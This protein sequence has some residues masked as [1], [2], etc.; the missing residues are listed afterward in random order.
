MMDRD[1]ESKGSCWDCAECSTSAQSWIAPLRLEIEHYFSLDMDHQIRI[2]D[3]GSIHLEV[4]EGQMG[5]LSG[6]G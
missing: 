4:S 1:S 3:F 6:S 5:G 2:P